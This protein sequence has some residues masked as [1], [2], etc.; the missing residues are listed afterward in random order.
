MLPAPGRSDSPSRP[1]VEG[2]CL[3]GEVALGIRLG[4]FDVGRVVMTISSG[5]SPLVLGRGKSVP[6]VFDRPSSG[7]GNCGGSG[8]RILFGPG[9]SSLRNEEGSR[10]RGDFWSGLPNLPVL[11]RDEGPDGVEGTGE[12]GNCFSSRIF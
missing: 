8:D 10:D 6:S 7:R 1:G 12:S 11:S 5:R 2:V 4:M 9:D 3:A